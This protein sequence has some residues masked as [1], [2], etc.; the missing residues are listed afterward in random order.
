MP[1][2]APGEVGAGAAPAAAGRGPGPRPTVRPA[3]RRSARRAE[4]R[5][6]RP[7]TAPSCRA[8]DPRS[9]DQADPY[10]HLL[11]PERH[12]AAARLEAADVDLPVLVAQAGND[13]DVVLHG[14]V[15][16]GQRAERPIGADLEERNSDHRATLRTLA[17]A[18][19]TVAGLTPNSRCP[20]RTTSRYRAP[21]SK[22]RRTQT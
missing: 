19:F 5:T 2:P 18:R 11:P 10:L 13:D 17:M 9:A 1:R 12:G 20:S 8:A 7:W 22:L 6:R 14:R 21:S 3:R 15:L 16:E 4:D